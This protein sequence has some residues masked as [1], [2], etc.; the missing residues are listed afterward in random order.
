MGPSGATGLD[1]GV[2]FSLMARQPLS[3]PEW[4]AL[5]ADLQTLEHAALGAIHAKD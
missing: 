4:D 1:Y 3:P 5:L 2:V